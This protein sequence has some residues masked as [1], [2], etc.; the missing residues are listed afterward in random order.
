MVLSVAWL[1]AL[2]G[3]LIS[4]S[5]LPRC[6]QSDLSCKDV[7]VLGCQKMGCLPGGPRARGLLFA[8][9][10]ND[11]A[12][13]VKEAVLIRGGCLLGLTSERQ[14]QAAPPARASEQTQQPSEAAKAAQELGRARLFMQAA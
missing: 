11:A 7:P 14:A 2:L 8:R 5:G 10:V 12:P 13:S 1:R 4:V 3:C 6:L 9:S